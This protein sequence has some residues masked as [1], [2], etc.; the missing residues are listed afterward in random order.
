MKKGL[1]LAT[2]S[3]F[4]LIACSNYASLTPQERQARSTV[5]HIFQGAP[6]GDS[7]QP[8]AWGSV[9][10]KDPEA[11]TGTKHFL[12]DP[13]GEPPSA[14]SIT[15]RLRMRNGFGM[16]VTFDIRCFFTNES[17]TDWAGMEYMDEDDPARSLMQE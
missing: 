17:C 9:K 3:M 2:I 5:K 15:H 16:E 6:E 14:Y 7:Y 8:I 11:G 10:F 12:S 4:I 1:L 13:T